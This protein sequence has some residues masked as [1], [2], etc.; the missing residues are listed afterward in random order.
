MKRTE[1]MDEAGRITQLEAALAHLE[2]NYDA[3]NSV[4]V[5][6]GKTLLRLQ[7][8]LEQLDESLRSQVDAGAPVQNVKPPHY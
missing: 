7:R 6:Q 5:A 1:N 4:V 8:R 3:L 2:R